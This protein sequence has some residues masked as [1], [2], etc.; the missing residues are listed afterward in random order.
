MN[1]GDK[2]RLLRGNEEGTIT[3]I[4]QGGRI[5][6]EI[7]DGFRIP[8]MRNEVVVVSEAERQYF[9]D[10]KVAAPTAM[11]PSKSTSPSE[12]GLFLGYLPLNDKDLSLYYINNT[13]KDFAYSIAEVFGENSH[14]ISSG[15]SAA[16]TFYKLD[17]KSIAKFEEW[18]L[19][20]LQFIPVNRRIEKTLPSF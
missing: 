2:V 15:L 13:D 12:E 5:E 18:P 19:L 8:A 6:I 17:E 7:E 14:T 11:A 9:G 3:R 16:R 4:S 1:V 10:G 20:H